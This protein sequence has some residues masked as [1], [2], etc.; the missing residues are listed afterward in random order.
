MVRRDVAEIPY[1]EM[2][3]ELR[4]MIAYEH[5]GSFDRRHVQPLLDRLRTWRLFGVESGKIGRFSL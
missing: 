5:N 2:S 1:D 3:A 4:S